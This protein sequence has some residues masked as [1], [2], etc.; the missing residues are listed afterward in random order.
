MNKDLPVLQDLGGLQEM[1]V[2]KD[3][4]DFR[5]LKDLKDPS[6]RRDL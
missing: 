3:R 5:D 1:M 6:D 2:H 4:K